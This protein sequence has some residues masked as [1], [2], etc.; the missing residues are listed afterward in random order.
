[1]SDGQSMLVPGISD[2]SSMRELDRLDRGVEELGVVGK[3]VFDIAAPEPDQR[4]LHAARVEEEV[5]NVEQ[6]DH[7]FGRAQ[8]ARRADLDGREQA[9]RH[10][11]LDDVVVAPRLLASRS[12]R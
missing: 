4:R 6:P 8:A 2:D 1:M 10:R 5:G 11:D 9:E 7:P 3:L 12:A